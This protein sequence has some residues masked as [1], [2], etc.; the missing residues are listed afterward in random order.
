MLAEDKGTA[1]EDENMVNLMGRMTLYREELKAMARSLDQEGLSQTAIGKELGVDHRTIGRWLSEN[2]GAAKQGILPKDL[3]NGHNV[4][5]TA[6]NSRYLVV[7]EGVEKFRPPD[8]LTFPLIIAD[9]PW[10]VSD[11]GHKRERKVRPR[12]FTKDFG[13]W[14]AFK[15]NRAYLTKCRQWLQNLYEVAAPD[16]WLFF[17]CSYRYIS[18]ILAEAQRAGWQDH[19]FYIWHK[20]NPLPMFG[21]NNFLQCIEMALVLAKGNPRFRFGK[22]GG[23]QPMNFFE[24]P[25]VAG[26]ER[27][28]NHD[29]SAA[30]LAQKSLGLTSL[31]IQWASKPGDWVLDAFAGTGTATVAA[32]QL[33]RNACAVEIDLSLTHQIQAR[34]IRE[35][36]GAPRYE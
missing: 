23:Q 21:N 14:D 35:C 6:T 36:I 16:A 32:L 31:W 18:K 8:G 34:L 1:G 13:S 19:T 25:Q 10:N 26:Y 7:C 15:T 30:S 11:P 29:G 24:S 12:P 20:T 28:R 33:G 4:L 27:V 17:W 3:N 2:D 9:P 22:R 5:S